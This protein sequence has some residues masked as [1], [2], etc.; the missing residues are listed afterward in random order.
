MYVR[1]L[2]TN[3]LPPFLKVTD[4]LRADHTFNPR[5]A[6][7][8]IGGGRVDQDIFI[9][10]LETDGPVY[11]GFHYFYSQDNIEYAHLGII[12]QSLTKVYGAVLLGCSQIE[13]S[14]ETG[15][16]HGATIDCSEAFMFP[17]GIEADRL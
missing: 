15:Y 6:W 1:V 3:K 16:E 17:N 9:H 13:H 4:I 2:G 7:T 12:W 14:P 8:D 10:S 11:I 5:P